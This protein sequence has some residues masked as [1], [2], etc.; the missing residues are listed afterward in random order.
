MQI[1]IIFFNKDEKKIKML[2]KSINFMFFFDLY[3][4][5]LNYFFMKYWIYIVLFSCIISL[6]AN[7]QFDADTSNLFMNSNPHEKQLCFD[8]QSNLFLRNNEYF[9]NLYDGMTLIGTN[10][11]PSLSY[12][13]SSKLLFNI[14]WYVRFF[15]GRKQPTV[16]EIFYRLRYNISPSFTLVMGDIDGYAQ[17]HLIEP[18]MCTDYYYLNPPEK[19]LQFL[20][21][22]HRLSSDL[23]IN[24]QKFILP[25]DNFKEEF[26]LGNTTQLNVLNT[27]T[28][29]I[30]IPFNFTAK[31]KGGQQIT[32]PEPL[33]TYFNSAIGLNIYKKIKNDYRIGILCYYVQFNDESPKHIKQYIDGYGIYNNLYFK[34]KA[35][36]IYCGYWYGE[37]Y[38]AAIGEPLFQSLSQKYVIYEEPVK[39]VILFKAQYKK[40]LSTDVPLFVRFEAYYDY[41]RNY[42]DFSYSLLINLNRRFKLIH[43]DL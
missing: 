42:F 38:Y 26:V 5:L 13:F 20:L 17:H 1:Y 2:L 25:G 3:I 12:S 15:N 31:H 39:Q 4:L 40:S 24:W 35:F 8:F 23:W 7:A 41:K 19:G 43:G 21:K 30:D 11:N 33:Q 36:D 10:F 27:N 6:N 16:N 22:N 32:S 37:Y 34:S 9:N 28:V 18:L 14:G 29:G